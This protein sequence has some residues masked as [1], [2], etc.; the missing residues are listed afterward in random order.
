M[1][2]PAPLIS[3]IVPHYN[4]LES[5][6]RCL[7]A[8][9]RQTIARDRFE[10]VVADNLSPVGIEAVKEC[11]AGRAEVILASERGAGPARNAGVAASRG[12]TLAFTDCDCDPEPQWLEQGI[13]ALDGCD[14][15]GGKMTVLVREGQSKSGPEAFECVFAFDNR[16]YVLGKGF[17]VTAN[18]FCSRSLFDDVGPF[19]TGVS[20]DLEWCTRA[21]AKGYRIGYAEQAIVGHP[22]RVS[23][24]EIKSKWRRLNSET[25]ALFKSRSGGR[26]KWLARSWALPLSIIAHTPAVLFSPALSGAGERARAWITLAR[27]RLWRFI[28]A[29]RLFISGEN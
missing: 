2:E 3:V 29:H 5:L 18:L 22:A 10:I 14:F 12:A 28:D 7:A 13:A 27:L 11:V 23:W 26:V 25:Y 16:S 15:A 4:D 21:R 1:S 8:L 20:E 17:T 19:L 9:M 24:P 6:D